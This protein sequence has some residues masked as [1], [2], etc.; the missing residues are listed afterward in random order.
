[1]KSG[2]MPLAEVPAQIPIAYRLLTEQTSL[3]S[4]PTSP[5]C[6]CP[7]E[8]ATGRTLATARSGAGRIALRAE[9][10]G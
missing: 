3:A 6:E 7:T 10:L 2:S 5:A 9:K 4:S 8:L 1:M